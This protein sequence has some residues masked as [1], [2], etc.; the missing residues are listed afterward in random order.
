[1]RI[2]LSYCNTGGSLSSHLFCMQSDLGVSLPCNAAGSFDRRIHGGSIPRRAAAA[3]ERQVRPAGPQL[4]RARAVFIR[5]SP[6][7]RGRADFP[8]VDC[9]KNLHAAAAGRHATITDLNM[10][11]NTRS[12]PTRPLGPAT[13]PISRTIPNAY[14]R[15]FVSHMCSDSQSL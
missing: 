9:G 6:A 10:V 15:S 13:A 5:P 12:N 14:T 8:G 3:A 2:S 4:N 1:M 11:D 7:I